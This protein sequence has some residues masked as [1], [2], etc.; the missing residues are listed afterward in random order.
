MQMQM[1]TSMKSKE[2][3]GSKRR[4]FL[5]VFQIGRAIPNKHR[6]PPAGLRG[7]TR[8]PGPH[9]RARPHD[10]FGIIYNTPRRRHF[11][12]DD[13][14]YQECAIDL[15]QR[16]SATGAA[17]HPRGCGCEC[18]DYTAT[19]ATASSSATITMILGFFIGS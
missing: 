19:A 18:G 7:E 13:G 1:Q 16:T 15:E 11:I 17:K 9:V 4:R 14:Y 3:S 12:I 6:K 8:P 10:I 2:H 5:Y